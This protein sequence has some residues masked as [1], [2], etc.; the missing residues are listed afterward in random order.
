MS[1][2]F[3]CARRTRRLRFPQGCRWIATMVYVWAIGPRTGM[4][5]GCAAFGQRQLGSQICICHVDCEI[6][7][8]VSAGYNQAKFVMTRA[9]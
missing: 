3:L 4:Y 9:R 8:P 6:G 2:L 7:S 5:P 1:F